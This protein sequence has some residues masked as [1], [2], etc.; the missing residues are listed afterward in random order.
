VSTPF[1]E[2]KKITLFCPVLEAMNTRCYFVPSCSP[3][4]IPVTIL[5]DMLVI[6]NYSILHTSHPILSSSL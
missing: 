2:E 4:N 1:R 3:Y 5:S 6:Y